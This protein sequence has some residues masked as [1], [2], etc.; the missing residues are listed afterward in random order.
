[1]E[2]LLERESEQYDYGPSHFSDA[3]YSDDDKK[4]ESEFMPVFT[5]FIEYIG[6]MLRQM[7]FGVTCP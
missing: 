5:D 7:I 3:I 4:F 2:M 1:M 6:E